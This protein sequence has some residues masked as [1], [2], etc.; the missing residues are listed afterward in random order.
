ML[1]AG[2][3]VRSQNRES[4][5]S[6]KFMSSSGIERKVFDLVCVESFTTSTSDKSL[7][8]LKFYE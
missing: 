1:L 3:L 8:L 7:W 2:W 5:V 6:P 4:F